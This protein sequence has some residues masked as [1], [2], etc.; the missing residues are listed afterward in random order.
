M[1]WFEVGPAPA[2]IT[3]SPAEAMRKKVEELLQDSAEMVAVDNANVTREQRTAWIDYR[4][5]LRDAL[6]Q[7]NFPENIQ[8]PARPE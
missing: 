3:V 7:P 4:Q 1:G 2:K 5:K 6:L 8:W